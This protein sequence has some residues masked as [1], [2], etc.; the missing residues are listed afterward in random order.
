M[1]L[2]SFSLGA[3]SLLVFFGSSAFTIAFAQG[4]A[5]SQSG[6]A[7]TTDCNGG[8]AVLNGSGNSVNFRSSCRTLTVNGS[9]NAIKIE[10]QPG[11]T[12]TLNGTGNNVSYTPTSGMADAAV[13]DHGQGN[14]VT[15]RADA[16]P[17]E[18]TGNTAA[19]TGSPKGL[20]I[21]GLNGESVQIGPNGIVAAPGPGQ[22]GGGVV[23][24]P[25]G[26]P[27]AA[28]SDNGNVATSGGQ[29]MLNG[30]AQTKDMSCSSGNV[31]INGNN[32]HFTLRGGCKALFV[33]GN[34]NVVHVELNAGAQIAIQGN[35][36]LVYVRLTEAG[37]NP[38]LLVSGQNC[39]VFLV[40][41][42]DDTTG[43]EVPAS[44]RS[45]SVPDLGGSL[46]TASLGTATA[47]L[48]PQA[49]M[50]FARGQSLDALQQDLGAVQTA[51]GAVVNLSGDVLFDFD[52]DRLRPDAQR[53]LAELAVLVERRHPHGLR[54]TGYTDSVGTAQY[55][56]G[57][58]GRRARNVERWL[59]DYGRVHVAGLGVEGRGAA[60]PMAPNALPNG[61]DNPAGRQQNRRVT[62]L[63]Q[64]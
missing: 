26:I 22:P 6:R 45:G 25:G 27:T 40:E 42:L 15:R 50:A 64:Q 63:L 16:A 10:L 4:A 11:G 20:A 55:N 51:E 35:N 24:S 59:R 29:L 57:L 8:D 12:I 17:G 53:S 18:T 56:L 52:R 31:Y 44:L 62:I 60:D 14:T 54:I 37:P 3:I 2:R 49:A 34:D 46:V 7:R 61:R 21:Q 5:V 47:I 1:S 48:T 36:A 38:Q 9:G 33:H 13:T 28:P 43:T 19:V 39:R 30:D 58:S 32:G 23:I 41:H